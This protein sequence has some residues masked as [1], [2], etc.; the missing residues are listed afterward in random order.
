MRRAWN[1]GKTKSDDRSVRK[2]SET[3]RRKRVDNFRKWR[4]EA[5]RVGKLPDTKRRFVRDG[6][7][8]ELIGVILGDG[9][10]TRYARTESLRIVSNASNTGFIGRYAKIIERVLLKR[11]HIAKRKG[12]HAVN[13]TIYQSN[14]GARLGIPVG[15]KGDVVDVLP[16]WIRRD[17]EF[18]LRYLRGL[19]EAEGSY[20][21]HEPT[22]TH[23]FLFT[24]TNSHLLDAVFGLVSELGFH[25][26]R[27]PKA[28]QVSRKEE[29]Q[30]LKNL[31][32]F[33]CYEA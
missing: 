18:V 11:P 26:H 2:I 21:V 8:A 6:D 5:R 30:K 31:L 27:S 4:E 17:R 22:Y 19:Y 16:S 32:G 10:I 29:V 13:I 14:L 15:A 3:M 23:K 20:C 28:I 24:N 25:P 33:R 1:E 7:L 9:S 12:S